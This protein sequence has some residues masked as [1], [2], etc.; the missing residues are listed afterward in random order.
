MLDKGLGEVE[1]DAEIELDQLLT[2]RREAIIML[3]ELEQVEDFAAINPIE[4]GIDEDYIRDMLDEPEDDQLESSFVEELR[5]YQVILDSPDPDI[6][7][8]SEIL[9]DL[10][11]C[12]LD[13]DAAYVMFRVILK[14]FNERQRREKLKKEGARKGHSPENR[15]AYLEEFSSSDSFE[16]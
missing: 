2:Y 5:E 8:L 1:D 12:V 16:V 4:L 6:G 10:I 7:R 3:F 14:V 9:N 15:G 13:T 11:E